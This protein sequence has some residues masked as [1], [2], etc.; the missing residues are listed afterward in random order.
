MPKSACRD[1]CNRHLQRAHQTCTYS[2]QH[3]ILKQLPLISITTNALR[4]SVTEELRSSLS[5]HRLHKGKTHHLP[6]IL[7]AVSCTPQELARPDPTYT[8]NRQLLASSTRLLF[9][10]LQ[11]LE[12]PFRTLYPFSDTSLSLLFILPI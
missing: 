9:F 4:K 8:N 11:Y 1:G 3:Q 7:L 12:S 2:D 5:L 10:L 6:S